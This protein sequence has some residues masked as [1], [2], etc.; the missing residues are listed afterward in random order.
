MYVCV[1]HAIRCRDVKAAAGEGVC[2]ATEVFRR[3]GVKPQCGRCVSTMKD[4][5]EETT[6]QTTFAV[7][8]AGR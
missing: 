7:G 1:C 3:A 8:L 2:R 6:A 5:L 4:M